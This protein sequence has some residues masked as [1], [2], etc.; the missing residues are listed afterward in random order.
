MLIEVERLREVIKLEESNTPQ[1]LYRPRVNIKFRY[2]FLG[3]S[4]L[5]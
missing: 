5:I 1:L 2:L 4:Q 3:G